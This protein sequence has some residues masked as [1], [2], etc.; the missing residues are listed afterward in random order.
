MV[1]LQF[2]ILFN[3]SKKMPREPMKDIVYNESPAL[4]LVCYCDQSS[5]HFFLLVSL[6]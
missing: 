5:K 1:E 2:P 6:C 4:I 3:L